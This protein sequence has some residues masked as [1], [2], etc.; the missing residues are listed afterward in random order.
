MLDRV[1]PR[2]GERRRLPRRYASMRAARL[3][4]PSLCLPNQLYHALP[5]LAGALERAGHEPQITDLNLLAAD[6]FLEPRRLLEI[7]GRA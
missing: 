5:M 6:R 2:S 4:P 7:F 3:F 1:S